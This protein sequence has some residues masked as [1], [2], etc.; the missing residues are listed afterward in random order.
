M[1]TWRKEQKDGTWE[2]FPKHEIVQLTKHLRKVELVY[3][4]VENLIQLPDAVFIVDINKEITALREA[5]RREIPILAIV[6]TNSDPYLVNYPI[7][8][9]DDAVGSIT[10]IVNYISEAYS[11][12]KKM[13]EKKQN[14]KEMDTENKEKT[15]GKEEDKPTKKKV[16]NVKKNK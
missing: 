5:T 8:A 1:N 16:E 2:K 10:Y 9:N 15:S 7:P 11:E 3:G 12:G 14:G 6:D 4:G 13:G